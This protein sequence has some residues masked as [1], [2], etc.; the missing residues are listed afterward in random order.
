MKKIAVVYA[1]RTKH[2]KKLAEAIGS[3][4][5]VTVLNIKDKPV[6][7]DVQLL[8]IVGGIYGGVSSPELLEF[9][10]SLDVPTLQDAALVTSCASA[11]QRQTEVHNILLEKRI[12]VLDEFVCKGS[13][14]VSHKHPNTQ[15]VEEAKD[16][17]IRIVNQNG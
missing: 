8:F 2:S 7:D 9:V 15:D 3:A 17:A 10:R 6:L 5:K 1:T 11:K 12:T 13:M 14:F 4:L 16:F